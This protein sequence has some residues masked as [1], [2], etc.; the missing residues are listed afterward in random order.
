MKAGARK[1]LLVGGHSLSAK[2]LRLILPLISLTLVVLF[3]VLEI[4]HYNNQ[5]EELVSLLDDLVTIQS[6]AFVSS[7]WEYDISQITALLAD[8]QRLPETESAAVY[9]VSGELL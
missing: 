8:F 6:S 9:D 2:L 7:V 1:N 3:G 5:R 4:R